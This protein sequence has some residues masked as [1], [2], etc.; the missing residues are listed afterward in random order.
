MPRYAKLAYESFS[1]DV[2]SFSIKRFTYKCSLVHVSVLQT[3]LFMNMYC[4]YDTV[5]TYMKGVGKKLCFNEKHKLE[6]NGLK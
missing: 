6:K 3:Q 5:C 2:P 4:K 1:L